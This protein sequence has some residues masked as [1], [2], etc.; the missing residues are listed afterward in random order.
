MIPIVLFKFQDYIRI[1]F[2]VPGL[3]YRILLRFEVYIR[4]TLRFQDNILNGPNQYKEACLVF[5]CTSPSSLP[6]LYQPVQFTLV[7]P[8]RLVYPSCTSPSSVPQLYQSVQFTLV[9]PA[10][11]LHATNVNDP[12]I[13]KPL[14]KVSAFKFYKS[15]LVSDL[16]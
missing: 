16:H 11:F 4:F 13:R 1:L 8:A 7:V 5:S 15:K 9:D 3:H 10:R 2:Y 6:Q 14:K 12:V